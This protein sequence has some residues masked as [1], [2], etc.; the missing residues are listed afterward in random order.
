MLKGIALS[1]FSSIGFAS[2][3]YMSV[4]MQPLGGQ[5]LLG[6]RM[7]VTFPI[8]A[9]FLVLG[10]KKT[11]MKKL[12]VRLIKKPFLLI[13]LLATSATMGIQMWLYLWAPSN[14]YALQVSIGYLIMPISMVIFGNLVFGEKISRLKALCVGFAVIGVFS[15]ILIGGA[16]SWHSAIVFIGFPL[17]FCLRRYFRLEGASSFA[18]EIALLLPFCLWFV[19]STD[20]SAVAV[21]NPNIYTLLSVLALLSATALLAQILSS[22][23]IPINFF[24]L[25]IYVEPL[26]MLG[27]SLLLGEKIEPDSY[28]FMICLF[29][30]IC[31]LVADTIISIK[32]A[33][34]AKFYIKAK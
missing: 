18:L 9:L 34:R 13:I 23:L 26:L 33:K 17:Y 15:K 20:L 7:L 25:L 3:Y 11:E 27:V 5:E 14:G 24:G 31:F 2:I 4:F 30:A 8:V 16:P 12:L 1:L 22:A 10:G 28:I 6:Y 21:Q 19:S 32:R 29:M